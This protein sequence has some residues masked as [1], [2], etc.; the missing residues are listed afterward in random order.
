MG[1]R[2][3]SG[4]NGSDWPV[5]RAL[6]NVRCTSTP[7]VESVA[8]NSASGRVRSADNLSKVPDFRA[9]TAVPNILNILSFGLRQTSAQGR[10]DRFAR[11]PEN[12]RYLRIAVV[13]YVDF[14][15]RKCRRV[16]RPRPWRSANHSKSASIA[17]TAGRAATAGA[18]CSRAPR[19]WFPSMPP[20][21]RLTRPSTAPP[22]RIFQEDRQRPDA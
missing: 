7:A 21:Q 3:S 13:R 20:P 22:V 16:E 9:K 12:D 15:R 6:T 4:R 11:Q 18:A 8:T 5:G 10:F 14:R 1:Q 19:T 2:R 17:I